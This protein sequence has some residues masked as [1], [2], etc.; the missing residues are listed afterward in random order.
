MS[1]V[2]SF[3]DALVVAHT[4]M[5]SLL[6]RGRDLHVT[7]LNL[8]DAALRVEG[9]IDSL[10]YEEVPRGGFLSRLFR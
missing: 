6:V 10:V 4:A 5:G 1:D 7:R 9:H 3:D 8:E 2:E